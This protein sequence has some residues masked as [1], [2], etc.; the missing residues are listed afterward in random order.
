MRAVI[1][2]AYGGTEHLE[3]V[4]RE[5]P[6]PG[7][8]E[9]R[10]GLCAGTVSA[11]DWRIRSLTV[12][13]GYGLAVRAAMGWGGPRQPV[14][15]TAFSGVVEAVGADVTR[16]GPGDEVFGSTGMNMG[17]HAEAVV[18][19]EDGA[20]VH[21]PHV[22]MHSQAAALPFG[23]TT[24]LQ[25]LRDRGRLRAKERLCVVGASGAVGTAAVQIGRA[26]G[27]HVTAVCSAANADL[28]RDLGA[29]EVIAYDEGED[30]FEEENR[31]DVIFDAVGQ[32]PLKRRMR[33]LRRR[34]RL[35][36]VY[37]GLGTQI[38]AR[39]AGRGGRRARDGI[40]QESHAD[41]EEIARL[42]EAGDLRAVID[43]RYRLS[44]I[45]AAYDRVATGRKRGA[46]VLLPDDV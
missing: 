31:F 42:A 38:A 11:A 26:M 27:A 6:R 24:A 41:M 32:A 14:L 16:F 21:K 40:A 4:E 46:V 35:L 15:G 22:L 1:C 19:K 8:G 12:P 43:S 34:G 9:I 17:A 5:L 36:L 29:R 20:V 28:V 37:A 23:A 33:A 18:V 45:A 25:F 39:F 7:P 13:P 2:R 3:I 30:P 10:V 44:E